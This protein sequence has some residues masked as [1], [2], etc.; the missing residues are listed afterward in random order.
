MDQTDFDNY[1]REQYR[2]SMDTILVINPTSEDYICYWDKY[3]NVIPGTEKDLGFGKGKMQLVRY[4]A[5]KYMVEMK[6]KLVIEKADKMLKDVKE[7]REAKG[8]AMDPYEVNAEILNTAP[9]IT[10]EKEIEEAYGKLY[11][12]LVREFG[13]YDEPTAMAEEKLDQR[14]P[15]ERIMEKI[16]ANKQIAEEKIVRIEPS[17]ISIDPTIDDLDIDDTKPVKTERI[18]SLKK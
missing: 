5:E 15:E 14:S 13:L 6:N 9:R 17:T 4:I 11:G 7:R 3:P 12:G 2:K 1:K 18:E 8:L 10:N 16:A